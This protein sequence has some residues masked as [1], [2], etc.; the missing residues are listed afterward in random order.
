MMLTR[1]S[2]A[3]GSAA[4]ATS[5]LVLGPEALAAPRRLRKTS[6]ED[7]KAVL[8]WERTAFRTV[9]AE[10]TPAT[11]PP[12]GI[13][14]LGFTALAMYRAA[15]RSAHQGASSESAA[16]ARAAH[17]VL[18]HYFPSSTSNLDADLATTFATVGPGHSRTKGSRIGADAARDVIQSREGD[19]WMDPDVHYTK[20]AG[21]GVWR[22]GGTN[23]DMLAAWIGS[24]RPLFVS[25]THLKGPY[26]LGSAAWAAD[27]EEVRAVGRLVSADREPAETATALFYNTSNAGMAVADATVRYLDSHPMG[28]LETA[29]LFARMHGA[30]TDSIICTWQQKRDVGFWRPFQAISGEYDDGNAG[31]TPEP[32]WAPLVA[33]PN[34]SDYLSGH[35]GATSPQIEVVRLT[36]GRE[37]PPG[38]ALDDRSPTSVHPAVGDRVRGLP[39]PDLGRAAL[40]EGDERHLR[41]G[42][43]H[44]GPRDGRARLRA[45]VGEV[46]RRPPRPTARDQGGTRSDMSGAWHRGR[47]G[48]R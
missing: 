31:T 14:V 26:S 23:T 33:N 12:I 29:L 13:P 34:Y 19:G 5:A 46:A 16:V 10:Q 35:G 30:A 27:Y 6:A 48:A 38:D 9:Y 15:Q 42:P 44:R 4:V 32:G 43:Q 36:L 20:A 41:D 39:R 22:P 18:A 2:L 8:D 7:G 24:L 40:Q 47:C 3:A 45:L 17:D 1:R 25:V 37:H 28:I 11:P 21:P